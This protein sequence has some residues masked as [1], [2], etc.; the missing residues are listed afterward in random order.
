M[1]S[2][3]DV[4]CFGDGDG[5][6]TVV[7]NGGAAPYS[8]LWSNNEITSSLS[9]LSAGTYSVTVTD[10][11]GCNASDTITVGQNPQLS[12][13]ETHT[14]ASCGNVNGS[15]TL[16]ASGGQ[17][18]YTF[19]WNDNN[20]DQNRTT[21]AAG[22]Y[23]VTVEDAIQCTATLS[24][25]IAQST[26]PNINI[27]STD[28]S[29][30]GG[31]DGTAT[32][33]TNGGAAPYSYI[34]SNNDVTSSLSNLSAG[35]YSVTVTDATGCN[36]SDTITVGQNAQLTLAET[37]T[38]A[39]CGN[40]NGSITLTVNGGQAGYTF[41]WNNNSSNQNRTGLTA[42][43]YSVTAEDAA[44]CTATLSITIG[45]SSG[46]S[47]SISAT[48]VSCYGG[49]DGTATV[50]ATGGT[51]PYSY[52]WSNNEITSSISGLVAGAYEV[53]VTDA[54]GCNGSDTVNIE[55]PPLLE[56]TLQ[57]TDISCFGDSSA[58]ITSVV[59][60]GV[61]N[62]VYLWNN[63]TT[64]AGLSNQPAGSYSLTVTD[65]NQCSAIT[66]ITVSQPGALSVDILPIDTLT[67]GESV[68]LQTN[69][70]TNPGNTTYLWQ[71]ATGL[72]CTD[73]PEPTASVIQDTQ[74][75]VTIDNNGCSATDSIWVFIIPDSAETTIPSL[76][77]PNAFSPNNDGLNDVFYIYGNGISKISWSVFD[78]WGELVFSSNELNRGWD[79]KLNSKLLPPGVFVVNVYVEFIDLGSRQKTQSVMLMR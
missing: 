6:A 62:Y 26:G 59:S 47:L 66:D 10:A 67:I 25:T 7:A 32:V 51:V 44:Q 12:L 75:F 63:S 29:C 13:T 68:I 65:N 20:T 9:G 31:N 50:V 33:V 53:T 55:Q 1:I 45:Q 61:P 48:D 77:I 16:T 5:S 24:V 34:W 56:V 42:G 49:N 28:V 27:T 19:T 36:G 11:T 69:A 74:Y 4:S 71:P 78:R 21:L 3:T 73:C 23:T 76:F 2:A 37:H 58:I 8:Y 41:S 30:F 43:S 79:G 64:S 18:G 60:G 52:L 54:T 14:D 72:S 46:P 15:I 39:S 70:Q 38:D 22:S 40:A 35:V 17:P 57:S